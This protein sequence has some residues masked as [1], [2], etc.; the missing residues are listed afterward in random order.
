MRW[1]FVAG[2]SL[3]LGVPVMAQQGAG[4]G[5][6]QSRPE[7]TLK[8]S[9]NR[10]LV[11]V[12]VTDAHGNAVHG[13]TKSDFTVAEDGVPQ[14]VLA[15]DA[16]SFDRMTYVPPKMPALAAGNYVNLP[17]TPERGPLYVLYYD[18]V[19]IPQDDQ[20]RARAQ[21]VKFIENKP[22][23][24]RFAI[25]V[26]SDGLHLVQ[27]FTSD[28]QKLLAVVDPYRKV[29]HVPRVFLMGTNFGEGDKLSATTRLDEIAAYLAPM[30]GRKNLIW[31]SSKFPLSLIPSLS[32]TESYRNEVKTTLNMLADEQIAVY[33]VDA[34]GVV[35]YEAYAA[36]GNIDN[37][38]H[39]LEPKAAPPSGSGAN[40]HGV[41]LLQENYWAEDE[42]AQVTGGRA[43]YSTNDMTGAL[44]KAMITGGSYY[45]LAYSPSNRNFEGKLRHIEVKVKEGEYH[46]AY[47]RA[48]VGVKREAAKTAAGDPIETVMEHGAPEE[49][50]LI[51]GLHVA[52]GTA[53]EDQFA[54]LESIPG[55]GWRKPDR[56]RTYTIETTVMKHQLREAGDTAPRLEIA[57]AIYDADGWILNSTVNKTEEDS[58]GKKEGAAKKAYRMEI[59]LAAPMKAKFLRV[60]VRD[61]ESGKLGVMEISLAAAT[62]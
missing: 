25:F 53:T 14:K 36:P 58:A 57:A 4:S 11:D 31:F 13:L 42:I 45:T 24:A 19:N 32:E 37:N 52:A 27:G 20:I 22:E 48:Y 41:S 21:L 28:K 46:L 62:K 16:H 61:A 6:V 40:A 44:E 15:F 51:F 38:L 9:V 39:G 17:A 8:T 12:V 7:Y 23:G 35:L 5:K 33:P 56:P 55:K 18:L 50:G 59:E 29:P 30:P 47:R 1:V 43:I 26:A 3:L 34:S 60:A 54:S 49:H 10:V 2:L